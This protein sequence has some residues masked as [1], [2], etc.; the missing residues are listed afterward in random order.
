MYPTRFVLSELVMQTYV[1]KL[2][3]PFV[4]FMTTSTYVLP[5]SFRLGHELNH[6]LCN[7]H[8]IH[9]FSLNRQVIY[10]SINHHIRNRKYQQ[11]SQQ[12]FVNHVGETYH[13]SHTYGWITQTNHHQSN[14]CWFPHCCQLVDLLLM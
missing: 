2:L 14:G 4:H 10:Q 6:S 11:V 12:I 9:K 1:P 7:A 3:S 5:F 13:N 8:H